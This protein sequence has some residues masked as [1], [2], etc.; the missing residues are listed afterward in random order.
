MLKT[1]CFLLT[2]SSIFGICSCSKQQKDTPVSLVMAE[3]NAADSFVGRVDAAFKEKAEQLSNGSITI[4]IHYA[5]S[6]GNEKQ[7]MQQVMTSGSIIQIVRG[8]GNLSSYTK[9]TPVRTRLL[10]IPYTFRDNEHFWNFAHSPLAEE[11]L[12]EPYTL[13][14]GVRG[15]FFGSEGARHF[16][17]TVPIKTAADLRGKKIRVTGTSLVDLVNALHGTPVDVSYTE[18]YAA[19]NTGAVEVAD[20]PL[21]NYLSNGFYTV[22]PYMIC[23]GHTTGIFSVVINADCWDSLSKS[24]QQI[25]IQAG[26]HAMQFCQQALKESTEQTLQELKKKGAVITEV[27]DIRPWQE[28]C[29]DMCK[30]SAATDIEF[31]QQILNF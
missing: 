31:Y 26:Q 18:L 2:V 22:A 4:Q 19:L 8:P 25:L 23:D 5:A 1:I 21:L 17:S 3:V 10:A 28:I 15:L 20:Q 7:V 11:L 30:E 24:Q 14:L 6:L 27:R 13:G 16:F 29:A 9:G 12:T